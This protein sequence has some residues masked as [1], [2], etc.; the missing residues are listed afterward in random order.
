MRGSGLVAGL[1]RGEAEAIDVY[2]I[3]GF[4]HREVGVVDLPHIE[5]S[6]QDLVELLD[7][8]SALLWTKVIYEVEVLA[9]GG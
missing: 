9:V 3:H 6:D 1:A 4:G 2:P 7:A 5:C 8:E